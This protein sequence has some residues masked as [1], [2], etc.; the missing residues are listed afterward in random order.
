MPRPKTISDAEILSVARRCFQ[1]HGHSVSTR[2]I[3]KEA[4]ISQAVLYQRFGGKEKMFLLA[5]IP[6]P[7]NLGQLLDRPQGLSARDYLRTVT[8]ALVSH[9]QDLTPA[10]VHLMTYPNFDIS[11]LEDAHEHLLA[12]KLH[13]DLAARF[14]ALVE[15]GEVAAHSGEALATTLI[16]LAHTIGMHATM[17]GPPEA[18]TPVIG[19]EELDSIVD[20]LWRG[21]K[22][23]TP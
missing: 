16:G 14:S 11:H 18:G 9:F 7:P 15:S 6:E 10:I 13:E 2:D 19:E 23:P 4:G 12:H 8:R 1:A 21:M 22:P 5:M 3:A 17:R 20:V